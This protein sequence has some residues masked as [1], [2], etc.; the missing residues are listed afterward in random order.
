MIEVSVCMIKKDG[1]FLFVK[2]SP[3]E[4]TPNMWSLPGGKLERT[5]SVSITAL[6]EMREELGIDVEVVKIIDSCFME[7]EN[8]ILVFMLCS[9]SQDPKIKQISEISE[10]KWSTFPEFFEAY[11]DNELTY[12]LKFLRENPKIWEGL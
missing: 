7:K 11:K 12:G 9:T 2:R 6:R 3:Q 10:M 8:I 5:E 4:T 1:K